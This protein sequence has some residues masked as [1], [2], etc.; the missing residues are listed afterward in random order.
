MWNGNSLHYLAIKR[1]HS[2][3]AVKFAHYTNI[4]FCG[5]S[6]HHLAIK[7]S[8]SHEEAIQWSIYTKRRGNQVVMPLRRGYLF[9]IE[10]HR[11]TCFNLVL[12]WHGHYLLPCAPELKHMVDYNFL[13]VPLVIIYCS[14][15]F[16]LSKS[17]SVLY[18][19]VVHLPFFLL[20]PD[21]SVTL[22]TICVNIYILYNEL[23]QI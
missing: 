8:Q 18:Y 3:I 6:L 12:L 17:T 20:L 1:P 2:H 11:N 22:S 15:Y 23:L 5:N 21:S 4:K 10:L 13:W 16:I 14:R 9:L 7:R 19:Y